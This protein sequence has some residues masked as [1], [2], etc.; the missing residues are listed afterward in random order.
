M[1]DTRPDEVLPARNLEAIKRV[2]YFVVENL[3]SARRFLKSVDRDIC[4]DDLN[5]VELNEHTPAADV[6]AMLDPLADGHDIGVISEAGCPA[7]ADPGAD[8]VAAAQRRGY[9][10][11]PLVGPSSIIM[12]LM[13]SGFNGQ[14]FAFVGYLPVEASRRAAAMKAMQQEIRSRRRTQIFIE[15]PYRNNRLIDELSRSLPGDM[16]LCVASD[17]TGPHQQILTL[18]LSQWRTRAYDYNKRPTIFLLY[19]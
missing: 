18:P 7:V 14:S 15:T 3:R 11:V 9:Q 8:L 6:E 1:G 5:M 4:I 2:R 17:I 13:A 16:L 12:S 10:V 19:S